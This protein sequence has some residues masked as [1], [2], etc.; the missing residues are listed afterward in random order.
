MA[1]K[2]GTFQEAGYPKRLPLLAGILAGILFFFPG[3]STLLQYDRVRIGEGEIWR[4]F[5]SHWTHWS[6][7]HLVWDAAVFIV[8]LLWLL[9][10]NPV[11]TVWVFGLAS[12]FIPLGVYCFLPEITYYRGLSG[13]DSA[14]FV[15]L[16]MHLFPSMR[17]QG[18][19]AGLLAGTALLSALCAKIAYEAIA[20]NAVFVG[21]MAPDVVVVP[22]AHIIGAMVG[23]FAGLHTSGSG[24]SDPVRTSSCR[25]EYFTILLNAGAGSSKAGKGDG[26]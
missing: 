24:A 6:M 12:L 26:R 13:L 20:C 9:R 15:F 1:P 14:L 23:F 16:A 18:D 8:L 2:V 19:R 17:R 3:A 22:L 11:K 10:V 7:E 4:L 5:T 21:N 25:S